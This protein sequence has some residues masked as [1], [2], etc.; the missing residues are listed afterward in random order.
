MAA[1]ARLLAAAVLLLLCGRSAGAQERTARSFEQ[2]Q[3]LVHSGD[4]ITIADGTGAETSGRILSLTASELVVSAR[5]G[6]RIFHGGDEIRVRQRRGDPLSNGAWIGAGVGVGLVALAAAGDDTGDID[7]PFVLAAS[8][9]YAAMGA[10]IGAGVDAIIRGRHVIYD[11]TSRSP[12]SVSLIPWLSVS[13][14]G[15]TVLWRF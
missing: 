13:R 14:I 2:L 11:N 7:A 3:M 5:D 9:I 12:A 6:R 15:A 4:A 8:G 10:G 1:I